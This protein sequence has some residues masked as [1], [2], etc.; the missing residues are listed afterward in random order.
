M[1]QCRFK[2]PAVVAQNALYEFLPTGLEG[3]RLNNELIRRGRDRS[4]GQGLPM[5]DLKIEHEGITKC[6]SLGC[7]T[8]TVDDCLANSFVCYRYSRQEGLGILVGKA[9]DQML[10]AYKI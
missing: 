1:L 3:C 5:F 4:C 2:R 8:G 6:A 7:L 10:T 9:A